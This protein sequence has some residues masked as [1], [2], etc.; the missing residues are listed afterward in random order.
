[1]TGFTNKN[2]LD[3]A[4]YLSEAGKDMWIRH[5]LVP[6]ITTDDSD[7][8]KLADF[9]SGLKTVSK[10]EVLP[11]HRL[12]VPEYERLGI[13]YPLPDVNPP[14]DE[15]IKKARDILCKC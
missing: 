2:I 9:I 11:Y 13:S 10:V 7:L 12:G 4:Q 5:V 15:E 6:G 3:M 14:S 8:K 1:M